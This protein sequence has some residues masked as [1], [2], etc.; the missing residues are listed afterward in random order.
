MRIIPRRNSRYTCMYDESSHSIF[1]V[2]RNPTHLTELQF[3]IAYVIF[4][5]VFFLAAFFVSGIVG[6]WARELL[7]GWINTSPDSLPWWGV[8]VAAF[9]AAIV[10]VIA[11]VIVAPWFGL[12]PRIHGVRLYLEEKSP[13]DKALAHLVEDNPRRLN[14][15]WMPDWANAEKKEREEMLKEFKKALGYKSKSERKQERREKHKASSGAPTTIAEVKE[16]EAQGISSPS[17]D[18]S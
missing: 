4:S 11:F 5:V 6:V 1:T 9:P 13:S 12:F 16:R 17:G 18:Q 14:I 3:A 7:G 15:D 10:L 2:T 8:G